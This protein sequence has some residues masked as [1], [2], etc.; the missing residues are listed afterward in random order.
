MKQKLF[1]I[2]MLLSL[3]LAPAIA[4]GQPNTN[5]AVA[6]QRVTNA[7]PGQIIAY[8]FHGTV[9]CETCL[10]IEKQARELIERRYKSE[11]DA[12]R[13]VFQPVNYDEPG[14]AHYLQDYKLP[15]PS[16]TLVWRES[17]KDIQSKMLGQTWTLVETPPEFNQYVER[18]VGIF[19]NE[20]N[21]GT[22]G[23]ATSTNSAAAETIPE[24]APAIMVDSLADMNTRFGYMN[25]AFVFVHATNT[26]SLTNWVPINHARQALA[27]GWDI[28]VGL[29]E[30]KP[31]AV[32][33]HLL[34]ERLPGFKLPAVV[35]VLR[36]GTMTMV[37]KELTE[38][39]LVQEFTYAVSCGGCCPLGE[40]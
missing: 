28:K 9:R 2:G 26:P 19:L 11:L 8:Y 30:W 7:P 15:C 33:F 5:A 20:L 25:A 17:G 22:D 37:S 13:L 6:A 38:T 12:K 31:N 1:R 10:K 18:E 40:P 27:A 36:N 34:V 29:F 39:N 14:N 35:I 4:A 16:L 24:S 32:D 23:G 3:A 21:S